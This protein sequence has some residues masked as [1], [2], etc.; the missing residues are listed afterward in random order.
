MTF[1]ILLIIHIIILGIVIW[2]CGVDENKNWMKTV[3][4]ILISIGIII[5]DIF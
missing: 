3:G 4:S 1:D 2:I 5:L